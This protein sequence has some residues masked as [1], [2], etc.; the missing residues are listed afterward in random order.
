MQMKGKDIK[1]IVCDSLNVWK[2]YKLHSNG[3]KSFRWWQI[4][5]FLYGFY[6][7]FHCTA[8]WIPDLTHQAA[9]KC[10]KINNADS[11]PERLQLKNCISNTTTSTTFSDFLSEMNDAYSEITCA[12][13]KL[14]CLFVQKNTQ[15][16][17]ILL[18]WLITTMV[19]T[20]NTIREQTATF[21]R[22]KC[23]NSFAS[24]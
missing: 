24:N 11:K 19:L 21:H 9:G 15:N 13:K 1:N 4:F 2:E 14:L 5:E 6:G 7:I 16:D 3:Y 23:L 22:V 8:K 12:S 18:F 20:G 17:F 10:E